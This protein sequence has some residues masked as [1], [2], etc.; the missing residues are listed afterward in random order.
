METIV[1]YVEANV[2]VTILKL[3]GELDASSY[4]DLIRQIKTLYAGGTRDLLLDLSDL[5]FIASSGL[6]ALHS[7]ATIMRGDTPV[8]PNEGWQAMHTVAQDLENA[9]GKEANLKLLSPQQR[10][11][12]TLQLSGFDTIID[13]YTDRETAVNSFG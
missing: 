2:P 11:A 13:I 8:D 9:T 12:R 7:A 10:V 4:L 1:E 6:I 3:N 5:T